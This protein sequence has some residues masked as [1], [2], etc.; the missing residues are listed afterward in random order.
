MGKFYVESGNIRTVI[1][2]DDQEKAALWVVHRAMQ[3]VTPVHGDLELSP[4]EKC[5]IAKN[6]G[7]MVLGS[8]FSVSETGFGQADAVQLDTFELVVHW[9]QLMVALAKLESMVAVE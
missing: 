2:A 4:T 7:V 3:Q 6:E 8:E 1:S 5:E 9:N